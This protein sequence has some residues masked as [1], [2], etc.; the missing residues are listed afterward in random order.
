[1]ERT[2]EIMLRAE[3]HDSD[4]GLV[5]RLEGRFAGED[6]EHVR[7]L[8]T[9]QNIERRLVVDLKEVT[10]ID[11]LGEATLSLFGRLGAKFI[12]E[13]VYVLDVCKRLNLPLARNGKGKV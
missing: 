2:G 8:L 10:F 7:T 12:A 13:D 11:S 4:R 5:I 1:M 6:A 9:R 3:M